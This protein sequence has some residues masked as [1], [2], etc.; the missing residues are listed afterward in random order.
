MFV[1][2]FFLLRWC[3]LWVCY[4]W[5]LYPLLWGAVLFLCFS[6][7]S[8]LF[9]AGAWHAFWW[10][11]ELMWCSLSAVFVSGVLEVVLGLLMCLT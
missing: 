2:P 1:L 7:P 4:L 10:K 11:G 9:I 6:A 5:L 8:L 3:G